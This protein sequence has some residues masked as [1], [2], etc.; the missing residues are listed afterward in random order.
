MDIDHGQPLKPTGGTVNFPLR[1]SVP[2]IASV[3]ADATAESPADA[4]M[5]RA[6]KTQ[7]AGT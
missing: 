7:Q 3:F 1:G 5:A 2:G 4:P 6:S